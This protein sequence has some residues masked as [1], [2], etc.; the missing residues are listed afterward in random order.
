MSLYVFVC[1]L[2]QKSRKSLFRPHSRLPP[3]SI[4]TAIILSAMVGLTH[5]LFLCVQGTQEYTEMVSHLGGYLGRG[6]SVPRINKKR[7][8]WP[9]NGIKTTIIQCMMVRST[10]N[11]I[12]CV[13]KTWEHKKVNWI[14]CPTPTH[15]NL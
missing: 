4:E 15:N 6:C 8:K 7:S 9:P 13:Q 10:H 11:S 5:Y 12:F 14:M 3:N 1:N 2:V